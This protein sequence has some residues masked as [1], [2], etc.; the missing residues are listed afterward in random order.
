MAKQIH[1]PAVIKKSNTPIVQK[2]ASLAILNNEQA[3]QKD[4][5]KG[6]MILN[7]ALRSLFGG[8]MP[9]SNSDRDMDKEFQY[10]QKPYDIQTY[11]W[12]VQYNGVARRA[13]NIFPDECWTSTPEVRDNANIAL[14]KFDKDVHEFTLKH[15]V[16]THLHK[17]DE[18]RGIGE[19]GI[20]YLGFD[21]MDGIS[22]DTSTPA[23]RLDSKNRILGPS[24]E[25]TE[26]IF[27]RAFDQG[28][29]RITEW[30]EETSSARYG[31]PVMYEVIFSASELDQSI[32]HGTLE[33]D[34]SKARMIHWTRV[35]HSAE[36]E[37]DILAAPRLEPILE[38]IY[39]IKKVGGGSG[40][41]FWRAAMPGYSFE[42]QEGL[43]KDGNMVSID[44]DSIQ[45]QIKLFS[46]GLQRFVATV[47]MTAKSLAPQV[48]KP[49]DHVDQYLKLICICIK[50]PLPIFIGAE[51]G[52]LAAN[53]NKHTWNGRLASRRTNDLSPTIVVPFWRRI[54]DMQMISSPKGAIK[55]TWPTTNTQ[56]D[57]DRAD[58]SL[59]VIQTLA[60]YMTS[61][62]AKI[63]D[64]VTLLMELFNYTEEKAT[65]ITERAKKFLAANKDFIPPEPVQTMNVGGNQQGNAKKQKPGAKPNSKQKT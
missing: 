62:A 53:N 48:T 34:W 32:G 43:L 18:R 41:M 49:N 14:S 16:N 8:Y 58:T 10:P 57:A 24:V 22:T 15:N 63:V 59:K 45:D 50:V 56:S 51:E 44:T 26:L 19:F 64:P 40:E 25:G 46:D 39:D 33:P 29:V 36:G 28:Q 5:E 42:T 52:H 21:D 17:L 1:L 38:Y 37:T 20:L 13:N 2:R 3:L 60:Q 11:K 55:T 27:M 23:A 54:A 6:R 47:G 31:Q 61:G 12:W 4:S 9:T 35:I 65:D 7:L 30:D